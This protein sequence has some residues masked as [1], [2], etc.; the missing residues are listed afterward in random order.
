MGVFYANGGKG[1][2]VQRSA[3]LDSGIREPHPGIQGLGVQDL[4]AP[5]LLLE[6][7]AQARLA[8]QPSLG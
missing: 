8:V 6:N 5:E 2:K 3:N 4:S 1:S 7:E